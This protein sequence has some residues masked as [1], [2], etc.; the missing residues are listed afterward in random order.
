MRAAVGEALHD[1]DPARLVAWTRAHI[2]AYLSAPTGPQRDLLAPPP[3]VA[4]TP[5]TEALAAHL[6]RAIWN[7]LPLPCRGRRRGRLAPDRRQS[8]TRR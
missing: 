4:G 8:C 3:L 7:A 5:A 6:G 2:G 1:E